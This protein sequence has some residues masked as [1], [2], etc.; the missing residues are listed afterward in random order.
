MSP[1]EERH[2][3]C[4]R[5][6]LS[7][8]LLDLGLVSRCEKRMTALALSA[9]HDVL[10]QPLL[11]VWGL[12]SSTDP[13]VGMIMET[14]GGGGGGEGEKRKPRSELSLIHI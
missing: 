12:S 4:L 14:L 13:P 8:E 10:L 7:G 1:F 11:E 5:L 2:A 9:G 3:E 6:P